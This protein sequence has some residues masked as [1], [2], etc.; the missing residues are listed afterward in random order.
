MMADACKT[1]QF[2]SLYVQLRLFKLVYEIVELHSAYIHGHRVYLRRQECSIVKYKHYASTSNSDDALVRLNCLQRGG[3]VET[4]TTCAAG[5]V[6]VHMHVYVQKSGLPNGNPQCISM[7]IPRRITNLF[8][9][10]AWT[11]PSTL[12]WRHR[13]TR[14]ALTAGTA[15]EAEQAAKQSCCKGMVVGKG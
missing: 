10:H 13:I 15:T 14:P 9:Q 3:N 1:H 6:I 12:L 4:G 5:R 7:A 8:G 11:H 2:P